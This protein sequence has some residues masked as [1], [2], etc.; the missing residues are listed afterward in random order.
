M[1][2]LTELAV[3]FINLIAP[4]Q[5]VMCGCRLAIGED[6]ICSSCNIGLPRTRYSITPYDNDMA[7][8]FWGRIPIEKSAALFFYRA[9]S[10]TSKIIYA[11]KYH[12]H[13][14]IGE[15][16]GRMATKE[17]I[18]NG[19]F[20]DI[21]AIVPIPLAKNRRRQRGF[22]QSFEIAR[23]V[24]ELTNIPIINNAV[25]RKTFTGSQTKLNRWQRND[26]VD[27]VFIVRNGTEFIN[28]HNLIIDDV[29]TTGATI[30]S[31]ATEI[32]KYGNV[33]FSV[34]SLGF[35]K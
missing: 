7:K 14:E 16:M 33:K 28:K 22:N 27:N 34:M 35:T 6:V 15:L 11:M 12:D 20:D 32:M 9:H 10:E 26:N 3:R 13:P 31:C 5:C 30:I 2:T 4:K 29:V 23:G 17:F 1:F 24:S 25:K 19:F 21:D 8:L 18:S